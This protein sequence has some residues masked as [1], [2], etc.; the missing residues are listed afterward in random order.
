MGTRA[1]GQF[2]G[3]LVK[4]LENIQGDE[5]DM[6]IISVCYGNNPSTARCS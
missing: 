1:D 4:N 6:V 2:V 3:L 5:R